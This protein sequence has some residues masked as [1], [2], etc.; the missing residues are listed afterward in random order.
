MLCG[1]RFCQRLLPEQEG[2]APQCGDRHKNINGTAD[3]R[4]RTAE[5]PCHQVEFE[6]ADQ[7]PVDT[8]DDKQNQ[9]EFI[10]QPPVK[11]LVR[12]SRLHRV[13]F[14]TGSG[15]YTPAGGK[16]RKF[17]ENSTKSCVDT[18]YFFIRNMDFTSCFLCSSTKNVEKTCFFL[19][20]LDGVRAIVYNKN[21][22]NKTPCKRS[23]C[24]LIKSLLF[25]FFHKRL[26][27]VLLSP[28]CCSIF[29]FCPFLFGKRVFFYPF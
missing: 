19:F 17:R 25:L 15:N 4:R 14:P 16:N 29:C 8:A 10:R 6:H 18:T 20:S 13:S 11:I 21:S 23:G 7:T 26:S 3:E 1:C 22:D 12:F 2:H 28:F 5:K 24:G 27:L 9:C